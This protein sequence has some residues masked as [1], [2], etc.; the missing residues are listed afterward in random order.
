M[1]E[2]LSLDVAGLRRNGPLSVQ[3][4]QMVASSI[5][6][7][8]LQLNELERIDIRE[9][10]VSRDAAERLALLDSRLRALRYELYQ[11]LTDRRPPASATGTRTAAAG[12]DGGDV[13]DPAG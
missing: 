10:G 9:N 12:E 1:I 11:G 13:N 2:R 3:Q 7:M 8:Q 5:T 4:A 6:Q